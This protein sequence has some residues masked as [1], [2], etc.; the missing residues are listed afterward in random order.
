[1]DKSEQDALSLVG[2]QRGKAVAKVPRLFRHNNAVERLR[3]DNG[4][5]Q[6]RIVR[7]DLPSSSAGKIEG[8]VAYNGGQPGA[9]F[10]TSG[11]EL[12][13]VGGNPDDRVVQHVSRSVW[14]AQDRH[15]DAEEA[16]ALGFVEALKRA[17]F[18]GRDSHNQSIN[19]IC[20][21]DAHCGIRALTTRQT[22][23]R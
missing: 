13:G 12:G 16:R 14:V 15:G 23:S 18:T 5:A 22:G 8:G 9:A 10:A 3:T 7:W 4:V 19:A 1:M 21:V 11:I 17:G 2:V 6:G 20:A